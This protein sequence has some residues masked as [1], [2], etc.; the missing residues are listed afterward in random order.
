MNSCRIF[1][2]YLLIISCFQ[3]KAQ[4]SKSVDEMEIV[5]KEC[6]HTKPDSNACFKKFWQQMDSMQSLLTEKI[7]E[8]TFADEKA[9]FIQDEYSWAK[10]KG[11]L[12]KKLDA[13]FVYNLQ[14]GIWKKDMIRISYQQKAE[15]ILKRI[16]VLLKRLVE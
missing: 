14:E 3:S 7:K 9:A 6:L 16:R 8:Q 15:F 10:K 5:Y 13:T 2:F 1:I 4:I 11:D 12:F